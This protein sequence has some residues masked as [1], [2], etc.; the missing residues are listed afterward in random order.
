MDEFLSRQVFDR[1][2]GEPFKASRWWSGLFVGLPHDAVH[3]G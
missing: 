1:L 2:E 3:M